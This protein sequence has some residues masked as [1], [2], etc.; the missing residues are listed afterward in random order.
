MSILLT[1][2]NTWLAFY[3]VM[4]YALFNCMRVV[5]NMFYLEHCLGHY[6][7]YFTH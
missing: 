1:E 7:E 3:N 6:C 2:D 5:W 4:I